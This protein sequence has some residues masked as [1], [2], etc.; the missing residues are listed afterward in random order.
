MKNVKTLDEFINENYQI[1]NLN[2]KDI[3]IETK[4][5]ILIE[6][7]TWETFVKY[8]YPLGSEWK[9]WTEDMY[10]GFMETGASEIWIVINKN[11][12]VDMNIFVFYM[13]YGDITHGQLPD[14]KQLWDDE[15]K[16]YLKNNKIKFKTVKNSFIP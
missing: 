15:I 2:K 9:S 13:Q 14:G 16:L 7:D 6:C 11:P 10:D 4:N 1:P 3:D 5:H 8:C 12:S